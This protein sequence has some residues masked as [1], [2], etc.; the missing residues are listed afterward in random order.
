MEEVGWH[1]GKTFYG[2]AQRLPI[3]VKEATLKVDVV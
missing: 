1:L 2:V 3:N